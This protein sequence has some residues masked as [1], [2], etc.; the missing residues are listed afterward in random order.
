MKIRILFALMILISTIMNGET[1]QNIGENMILVNGGTFKMGN[2]KWSDTKPVHKVTLD[3]FYINKYEVTQKEFYFVMGFNP[4]EFPGEKNPVERV[5]WYEAVM[6][7]NKLS[8]ISKL[9]KYYNIKV[10][11][12]D[13]KGSIKKAEVSIIGEKGYR[14]PT[15]AEW[16]YAARGGALS[17]G[18]EYSGSNNPDEVAQTQTNNNVSPKYVGSLKA[19]ELGLFDMIGNVSEWCWDWSTDKY[20]W[21]F[22]YKNPIGPKNGDYRVIRGGNFFY[23]ASDVTNRGG[24]TPDSWENAV[25]FR[26]VR[27]Y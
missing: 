2:K 14:L 11:E 25:G 26:I 3:S 16:E 20:E 27:S 19:N 4:S 21:K 10:L 24:S 23:Y 12:K 6:F 13:K 8:E 18:Y 1:F 15:E 17:K 5:T 22:S 7:C 9:P